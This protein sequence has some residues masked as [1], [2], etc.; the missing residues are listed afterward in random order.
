VI[1]RQV[2]APVLA[3]F[4]FCTAA[5][6][7]AVRRPA[8]RPPRSRAV[9]SL[10]DLRLLL[11]HVAVTAAGGYV[12]LLAIVLVFSV[13]VAGDTDAL[14]SAAWSSLFLLAV[15]TPVFVLLAVAFGRRSA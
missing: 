9:R 1:L 3:G 12:A 13:F 4:A 7:Y 14:P 8:P 15:A 10:A 5:A 11:R 2:V 6:L